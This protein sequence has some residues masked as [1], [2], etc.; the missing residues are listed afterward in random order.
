M[1]LSELAAKPKLVKMIIED[2]DVIKEYGEALEFYTYD[3]QPMDV[4]LAM[5]NIT[6][7]N[8]NSI[9]D[10]IKRLVLDEQGQSIIKGDV[11]L[12]TKIMLKVITKVV[13]TLGK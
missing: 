5:S 12:P 10:T 3:R 13:E 2:E 9:V 8:Y 1:K 11:T 4:F 7:E 6:A